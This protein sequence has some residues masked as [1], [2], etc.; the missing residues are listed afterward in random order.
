VPKLWQLGGSE[1]SYCNNNQ[2][3]FFDPPSTRY[4]YEMD[5]TCSVKV[6]CFTALNLLG[7]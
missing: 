4:L 7:I 5:Y 1:Q 2:A 6:K 3:Y